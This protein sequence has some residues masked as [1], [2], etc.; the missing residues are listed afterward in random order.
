MRPKAEALGYLIVLVLRE[1]AASW[2]LRCAEKAYLRAKAH[3]SLGL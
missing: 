2:I 1:G 3:L